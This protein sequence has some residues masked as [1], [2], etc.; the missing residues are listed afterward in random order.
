MVLSAMLPWQ[1]F[2]NAVS[3]ASRASISSN[4]NMILETESISA[5]A[6]AVELTV[7]VSLGGLGISSSAR[8]AHGLYQYLPT[9]RILT[10]PTSFSSRCVIE[11]AKAAP[12]AKSPSNLKDEVT[13][14]LNAIRVPGHEWFW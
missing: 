10:L 13:S 5:H 11:D 8:R 3:N 14:S 2:S 7:G 12:P 9:W 4:A 1:F 6:R